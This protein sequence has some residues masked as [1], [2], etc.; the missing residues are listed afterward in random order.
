MSR[1]GHVIGRNRI[2]CRVSRLLLYLLACLV[3]RGLLQ[4]EPAVA[5]PQNQV[6]KAKNLEQKNKM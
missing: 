2:V 3:P 1:D 6:S 4:N 5:D